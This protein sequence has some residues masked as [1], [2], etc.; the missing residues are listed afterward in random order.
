M[1]IANEKSQVQYYDISL[2]CIRSQILNED[3]ISVN[4]LEISNY[5]TNQPSLLKICCSKKPELNSRKYIQNDSFVLLIFENGPVAVLRLVCGNGH[6]GDVHTSGFTADVLIHQYLKLNNAQKAINVLLCLNWDVYGAML[7]IGLHKIANFIFKQPFQP[8]REVQ[9]QKAL[10]SFFVP[11]KPLGLETKTEFGDQVKDIARKFFQYL[12]RYKSFEKAFNLA[13]D[14]DDVDL[15]MD[16]TN[17][18]KENGCIE[19]A[20]DSY[21][22]AEQ[23][24]TRSDSRQSFGE[25]FVHL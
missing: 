7:M 13:I 24:Y 10:G 14:I 12:L 17:C 5:F 20:H 18:A 23:I 19:L 9:L 22:Q 8:E 25:P 2:A 6:K 1:I 3:L 15:F 21:Q 16:L 4:I 11:V